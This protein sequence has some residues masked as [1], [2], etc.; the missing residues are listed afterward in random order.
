MTRSLLLTGLGLALVIAGCEH[1][2]PLGPTDL[3]PTL[4]SIEARI[5]STSCAVSGCHVGG[6]TTL[7]TSMSLRPGDAF[8]QI[9][10]V[11]SVERPG[12][13]RVDPGDPDDS[14]LVMKI[15]GRAGIAG[16]RM[17]LGR[18]ALTADEIQ[19]IRA[20]ITDGAPDN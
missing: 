19:S 18:P 12:L 11:P 9:V 13:L 3:T 7:P 10:G 6:G 20:W 15:E 17:P 4:S 14:Y 5:F 1:A 16:A 2:D 8:G